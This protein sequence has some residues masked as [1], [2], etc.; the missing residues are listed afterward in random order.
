M[1]IGLFLIFLG[2]MFLLKN[3]GIITLELWAIIWP[4]IIIFCGLYLLFRKSKW[5]DW[6]EYCF[7]DWKKDWRKKE[8]RE[9]E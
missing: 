5:Y 8:E 7:W 6:E 9:S 1:L 3:L 4:A 2:I